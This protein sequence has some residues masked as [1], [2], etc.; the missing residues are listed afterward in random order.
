MPFIRAMRRERGNTC[1]G[2]WDELSRSQFETALGV[3]SQHGHA[4]VDSYF[5]CMSLPAGVVYTSDDAIHQS[6]ASGAREYMPRAMG[7]AEPVSVRNGPRR[8]LPARA[9]SG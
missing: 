8:V 2:P 4:Q 5:F 7:R 1:P 3:F 9:R 6:Y